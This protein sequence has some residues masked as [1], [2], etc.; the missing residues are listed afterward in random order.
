VTGLQAL[1]FDLDGTL[2]DSE[3]LHRQAFNQTFLKFG[4][5]WS[6]SPAAYQELLK[7]SGGADRM[8]AYIATL[9][10]KRAEA[11]R[12]RQLVPGVHREKTRLYGEL[13]ADGGNRL[14]S[15]VVRL[16]EEAS[17]GG[18]KIGLA[19][20]SA[21]R[22]VQPLLAS[23]FGSR[24]REP[25]GAIVGADI[26]ERKKPA[27]DIYELLLSTLRMPASGCVAFEDSTN[28]LKAAKTAGLCT[29]VTPSQWT[30][31]QDFDGADLLLAKLGDPDDPLDSADSAWIGGA[32]YLGLVEIEALRSAI[33]RDRR[34]AVDGGGRQSYAD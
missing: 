6:W 34:I 11:D 4:L 13:L 2:V 24:G 30:R 29:V 27:P 22:N 1:L 21:L 10:I 25:I 31:S 33:R 12:L 19:S 17:R 23:A 9:N 5:G 26:V 3:G 16:F 32:Q 18:L 20:T 14:R 15:G 8:F 28:G 7:V